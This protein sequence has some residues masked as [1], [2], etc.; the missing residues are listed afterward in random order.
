M[1][2]LTEDDIGEVLDLLIDEEVTDWSPGPTEFQAAI[3]Q[4]YDR[5]KREHPDGDSQW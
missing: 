3:D 2:I 1:T 5:Y 4:V